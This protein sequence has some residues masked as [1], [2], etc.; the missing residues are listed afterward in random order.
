[1]KR[2]RPRSAK[3]GAR[4]FDQLA[5]APNDERAGKEASNG[6]DPAQAIRD[7]QQELQSEQSNGANENLLDRVGD[8]MRGLGSELKQALNRADQSATGNP[9]AQK[10]QSADS[11]TQSSSKPSSGDRAASENDNHNGEKEAAKAEARA[12]ENQNGT[13]MGPADRAAQEK[14]SDSQSGA[15]RDEG[16]KDIRDA[17]QLRAVGKL[18]QI[19]GKR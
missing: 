9:A 19:I 14:G 7:L 10:E 6:G 13:P 16:Q 3:P 17:A 4:P 2:D 15:G 8:A 12:V 5:A 11:A 1:M 18:E